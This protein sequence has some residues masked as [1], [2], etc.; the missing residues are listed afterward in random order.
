MDR[1]AHDC[2]AQSVSPSEQELGV[3]EQKHPRLPTLGIDIDADKAIPWV[4]DPRMAA[5]IETIQREL[6]EGG[7]IRRTKSVRL[8]V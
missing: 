7:L 5:T 3:P 2:L 6:S 8:M 1:G 4:D